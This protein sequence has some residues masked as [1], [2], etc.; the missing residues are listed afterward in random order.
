MNHQKAGE[1]TDAH[2]PPEFKVTGTPIE[3]Q[4]GATRRHSTGH[5]YADCG[6]GIEQVLLG[7]FLSRNVHITSS[8]TG[9]TELFGNADPLRPRSLLLMTTFLQQYFGVDVYDLFP[10]VSFSNYPAS[11]NIPYCRYKDSPSYR[12]EWNSMRADI[13]HPPGLLLTTEA[14]EGP[15]RSFMDIIDIIYAKFEAH[16]NAL[17]AAST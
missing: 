15:E 7:A 1:V 5:I 2:P 12:A 9:R 17:R 16:R 10:F 11:T 3:R 14:V 4:T 8:S 6:C 13:E